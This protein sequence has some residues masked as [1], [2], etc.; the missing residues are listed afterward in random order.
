M[1]LRALAWEHVVVSDV[2]EGLF[3]KNHKL[4]ITE[5]VSGAFLVIRDNVGV[6]LAVLEPKVTVKCDGPLSP[7]NKVDFCHIFF[8]NV[9]VAIL[10]RVLE[11]TRHKPESDLIQKVGIKLLAHSEE[12]FECWHSEDVLEQEF[13]HNMLLNTEWNRVEIFLSFRQNGG[14]IIFPEVAEV[15]FDTVF[16]LKLDVV[17]ADVGLVL[18]CADRDEPV[19]ELV[20]V[21]V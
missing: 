19:L 13:A 20:F 5:H 15:T 12:R 4:A 1:E 6:E 14:A 18:D 21:V 7:N 17:G 3:A 11:L 16:E 10:S 8:L 9:H 2:S